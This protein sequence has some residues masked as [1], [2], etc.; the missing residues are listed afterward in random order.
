[1]G[2]GPQVTDIGTSRREFAS[3]MKEC[4]NN[5]EVFRRAKNAKDGML[6]RISGA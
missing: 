4:C 2:E 5:D 3:R 1:M 6:V